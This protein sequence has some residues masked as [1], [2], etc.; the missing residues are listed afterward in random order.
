M[1]AKLGL[2]DNT[3]LGML[4]TTE[5]STPVQY[6]LEGGWGE[7]SW[8]NA[9][10]F[11]PSYRIVHVLEFI[12][13]RYVYES[14]IQKVMINVVYIRQ[15]T[16]E[17][18]IFLEKKIRPWFSRVITHIYDKA[19]RK[20]SIVWISQTEVEAKKKSSQFLCIATKFSTIQRRIR[21]E[22]KNDN[23][24]TQIREEKQD[25]KKSLW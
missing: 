12:F 24:H 25:K 4:K 13:T 17:K 7:E 9:S 8:V 18:M 23:R 1:F 2:M 10:D 22:F 20:Q 19:S 16:V 14:F 6:F 21:R 5:D 3:K 11:N 15:N